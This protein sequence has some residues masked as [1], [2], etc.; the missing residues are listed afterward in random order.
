MGVLFTIIALL[1]F[2]C[3]IS[4]D[5]GQK[6]RNTKF[7]YDSAVQYNQLVYHD[8]SRNCDRDTLTHL[9]VSKW[10]DKDSKGIPF[11]YDTTILPVVGGPDV[12]LFVR[13]LYFH[14]DKRYLKV[15]ISDEW[16]EKK[17]LI[18]ATDYNRQHNSIILNAANLS[19]LG[20]D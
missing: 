20:Y 16:L 18:R 13:A 1:V 12:H 4:A 15:P 5:T 7:S 11:E 2:G 19:A 9:Q 17:H 6:Q 14:T 8:Y 3:M 10:S